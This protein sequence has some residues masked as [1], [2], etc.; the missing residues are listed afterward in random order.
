MI[1]SAKG[2]MIYLSTLTYNAA[3]IRNPLM[4]SMAGTTFLYR[5]E[6]ATNIAVAVDKVICS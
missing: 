6:R 2:I 3:R 5:T 4:S 1:M